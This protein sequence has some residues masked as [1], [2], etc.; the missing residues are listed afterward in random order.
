M[1]LGQMYL[2]GYR[3]PCPNVAFALAL[4]WLPAVQY[5]V[6]LFG[7]LDD[8]LCLPSFAVLL[9]CLAQPSLP[10]RLLSHRALVLLGEASYGLY[11]LHWPAHALFASLNL[12]S[13]S[14]VAFGAYAALCLAASLLSLRFLETPLR[15]AIRRRLSPRILAQVGP[16]ASASV[17]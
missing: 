5:G 8:A 7:P 9:L 15:Y 4:A 16:L 1:V 13:N 14:P 6:G 12:P 3:I 11:I 2:G 17:V 10:T